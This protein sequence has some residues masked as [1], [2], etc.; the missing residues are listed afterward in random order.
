MNA[1]NFVLL[2]VAALILFWSEKTDSLVEG[3]GRIAIYIG[4]A[5][6]VGWRLGGWM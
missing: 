5:M 6:F 4:I 2:A 3:L 1:L